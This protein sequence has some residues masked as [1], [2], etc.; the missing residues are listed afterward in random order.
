MCKRYSLL[1]EWEQAHLHVVVPL[2]KIYM[3][4]SS[5]KIP[6]LF[7]YFTFLRM[8]TGYINFS[9]CMTR[10]FVPTHPQCFA[11]TI[12]QSQEMLRKARQHNNT[13]QLTYTSICTATAIFFIY[14]YLQDV[15][16]EYGADTVR[17]FMLFKAPPELDIQWDIQGMRQL[18]QGLSSLGDT[19]N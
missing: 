15:V 17:V 12:T 9:C 19:L 11:L 8:H 5:V 14:M 18:Y 3:T 13:P 16:R 10:W 6:I 7:R 1:G 4:S 2:E